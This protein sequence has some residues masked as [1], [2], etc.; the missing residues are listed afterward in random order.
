METHYTS[1]SHTFLPFSFLA[2]IASGQLPTV[3]HPQFELTAS[4]L[5]WSRERGYGQIL[6]AALAVTLF[7]TSMLE[8]E[9]H[10]N[11]DWYW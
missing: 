3:K 10:E 11:S 7:E 9:Q 8:K 4:Q 2:E 1:L 5:L 6:L